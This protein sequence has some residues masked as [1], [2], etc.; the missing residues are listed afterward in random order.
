MQKI[1]EF[2]LQKISHVRSYRRAIGTDISRS[3]FR[4]CLR[5]ENRLFNLDA[6]GSHNRGANISRVKIFLLEVADGF[7]NGFAGSVF[8]E[9]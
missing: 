7:D 2:L 5:L 4:F 6:D 3:E 9:L 8:T 1:V